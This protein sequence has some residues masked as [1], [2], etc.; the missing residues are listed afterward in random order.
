MKLLFFSLGCVLG[1][2]LIPFLLEQFVI[3]VPEPVCVDVEE[4]MSD[5]SMDA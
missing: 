4:M 1:S 5:R 2:L 3:A